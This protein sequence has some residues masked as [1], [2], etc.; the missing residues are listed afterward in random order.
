MRAWLAEG[1]ARRGPWQTLPQCYRA[2]CKAGHEALS[3]GPYDKQK[4][5]ENGNITACAPNTSLGASIQENLSQPLLIWHLGSLHAAACVGLKRLSP[6]LK[7]LTGEP[8]RRRADPPLPGT[9]QLVCGMRPPGTHRYI[10]ALTG[11]A[12]KFS[13]IVYTFAACQLGR[14]FVKCRG[15]QVSRHACIC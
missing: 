15:F 4:H 3:A 14:A 9:Q 7:H 2:A 5:A 10:N 12:C 8:A 13:L 11:G 1:A 6:P